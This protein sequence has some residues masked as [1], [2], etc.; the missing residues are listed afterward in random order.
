M[1]GGGRTMIELERVAELEDGV[2]L[3]DEQMIQLGKLSVGKVVG[4][5]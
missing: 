5:S 2:C 1:R 3:V 4:Q